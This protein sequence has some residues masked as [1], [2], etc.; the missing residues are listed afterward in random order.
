MGYYAYGGGFL[1]TENKN[2]FDILSE[3]F[4]VNIWHGVENE[5]DLE[6]EYGK[7]YEEGIFEA[8]GKLGDA[9]GVLEFV[10]EDD[11]HWKILC[12][13]GTISEVCGQV[14]Y[15]DTTGVYV[16]SKKGEIFAAF[17]DECKARRFSEDEELELVKVPF[18]D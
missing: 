13:N 14:I 8:L 10:G 12:D 9:D 1:T 11:Q 16:V 6:F 17:L 4:N 18:L 5:Y 3:F 15:P 7:Y 2:A